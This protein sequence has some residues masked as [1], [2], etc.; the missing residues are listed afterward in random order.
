M[1]ITVI[2]QYDVCRFLGLSP[3]TL[4]VLLEDCTHWLARVEIDEAVDVGNDLGCVIGTL[5]V[6]SRGSN[7]PGEPCL[8]RSTLI[9]ILIVL[10]LGFVFG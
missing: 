8:G 9:G 7:E 3:S 6:I 5:H 10:L 2:Q 4:A 1:T